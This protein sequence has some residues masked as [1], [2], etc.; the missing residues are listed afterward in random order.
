MNKIKNK[1]GYYLRQLVVK[2]YRL[3]GITIGSNVFISHGCKIDTTYPDSIVIED[4]VYI[5]YGAMIIAHDHSVYR[6]IPHGLDNGKGK[7]ILK[8]NAFIGAGAI[9]LRNVTIGENA[10][11]AAGAVVTT[12][13]PPNCIVA[14]NP[15]SI[16]KRFTPKE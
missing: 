10:I 5:T 6:C 15:A 12:D 9:I 2:Y 7:V 4:S 16:I 13:V 3:L 11:V 14:G 1:I 8:K